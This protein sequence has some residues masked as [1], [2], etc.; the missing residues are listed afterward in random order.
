MGSIE[1]PMNKGQLPMKP[2]FKAWLHDTA[3]RLGFDLCGIAPA[4]L[5]PAQR[6]HY[7]Q[8]LER[9]FHGEMGYMKRHERLD[10]RSLLPS[11]RSVICVGMIYQTAHPLSV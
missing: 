6:Q 11:A 8:W 2:D 5:E 10:L 9:G 1:S 4:Q 7:V 3:K